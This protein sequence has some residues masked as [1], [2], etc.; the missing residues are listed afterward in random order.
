MLIAYLSAVL[1]YQGEV[2]QV[3]QPKQI[4]SSFPSAV[5]TA[6]SACTRASLATS[7]TATL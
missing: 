1:N 6:P 3:I 4:V 5:N 7:A 2:L